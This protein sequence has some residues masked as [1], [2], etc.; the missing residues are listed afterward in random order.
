[1]NL[2]APLYFNGPFASSTYSK[3]SIILIKSSGSK[4]DPI[5]RGTTEAEGSFRLI[6]EGFFVLWWLLQ[7]W[8]KAP[9]GIFGGDTFLFF[10]SG[11]LSAKEFLQ[12]CNLKIQSMKKI[13]PHSSCRC[14]TLKG[15]HPNI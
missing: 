8:P 14:G 1:M 13:S 2:V 12:S 9:F 4:F 3:N 11:V 7:E 5:S 10:E 6:S 15:L